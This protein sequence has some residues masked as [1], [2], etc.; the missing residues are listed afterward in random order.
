MSDRTT[1]GV[2]FSQAAKYGDRA[3]LHHLEGETW[4][5]DSWNDVS[6]DV[7]AVASGLIDAGVKPADCVVLIGENRLEW[8]LCDFA[9]QAIGAITVPIYPNSTPEIAQKII[10]N[11]EATY[12]I[13]DNRM[14]ASKLGMH[15]TALMD[16][17]VAEWVRRGPTQTAEVASRLARIR[18]DDLCTIVYTS[19]T[20]GDPKGVELAHRCVVDMSRSAAKVHPIDDRDSTLSFLPWAHVFGRINDIFIGIVFGGQAWISRGI[21][22]LAAELHEVQPTVMCSVPR[23]YEKMYAAVMARVRQASPTRQGLFR[24]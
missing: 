18:P 23:M 5:T 15:D 19:G 6:R 14:T 4:K 1:L 2:F 22:H 20:T 21:D 3:L 9:I 7:L 12:A 8:L 24:W 16:E 10:A 13:A 11:S 17:H